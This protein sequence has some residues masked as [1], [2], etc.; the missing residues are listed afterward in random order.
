M[1]NRLYNINDN[2]I[3]AIGEIGLDYHY[4]DTDKN[5]QNNVFK[6]QI[7]IA[8]KHNK[9]VIIHSRDSIQD[10]YDILKKYKIGG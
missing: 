9:P 8:K 2:K 4:D 5:K 7:E 10:T 1:F 6:K 3:V